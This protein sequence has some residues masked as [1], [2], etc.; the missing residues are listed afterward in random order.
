MYTQRQLKIFQEDRTKLMT[1]N[2]LRRGGSSQQLSRPKN[3][4]AES[5]SDDRLE[6]QR[7]K[8]CLGKI[9]L[10]AEGAYVDE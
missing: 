4:W 7:L 10:L 6:K 3:Q 5:S 8:H 9:N 1:E 2:R